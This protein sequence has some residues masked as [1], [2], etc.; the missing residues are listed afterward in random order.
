MDRR[1]LK[2]RGPRQARYIAPCLL[3][4]LMLPT[5]EGF[6]NPSET[7]SSLSDRVVSL[8]RE[9]RE[10]ETQVRTERDRLT[11]LER[12]FDDEAQSA[13]M[14]SIRLDARV[15]AL[16][17]RLKL[18]EERSEQ[19]HEQV[20]ARR[21][22]LLR[23]ADELRMEI[24]SALPF[25][26][27]ARSAQLDEIRNALADTSFP[28][29]EAAR[30]LWQFVRDELRLSRSRGLARYPVPVETPPV[31]AYVLRLGTVALLFVLPDGRTG[32]TR[33]TDDGFQFVFSNDEE[34]ADAVR[35]SIEAMARSGSPD[36]LMIPAAS[37]LEMP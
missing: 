20:E 25:R 2:L 5:S 29:P 22:S 11:R 13:E 26:R 32:Y 10:L 15:D 35:A 8:R 14:A 12:Q 24:Q 9:V 34:E 31:M 1:L 18:V 4:L 23:V 28:L 6:T 17:R 21:Q 19:N 16:E 27:E 7:A 3:A 30:A 37:L 36:Q 33:P